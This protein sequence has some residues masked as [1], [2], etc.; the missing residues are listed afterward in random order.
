MYN[1]GDRVE[2]DDVEYDVTRVSRSMDP[3]GTATV[4]FAPVNKD[5]IPGYYQETDSSFRT[6]LGGVFWLTRPLADGNWQEKWR[7]VNVTPAD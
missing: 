7:R 2:I 1:K 5:F 4:D 3:S 6:R